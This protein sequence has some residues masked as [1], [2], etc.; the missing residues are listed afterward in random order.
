MRND[1]IAKAVELFGAVPADVDLWDVASEPPEVSVEKLW[2]YWR[3][4]CGWQS[5][6]ERYTVMGTRPAELPGTVGGGLRTFDAFPQNREPTR[7]HKLA[8]F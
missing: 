2:R 6:F 7:T 5:H 3:Q 8:I 4:R 1:M